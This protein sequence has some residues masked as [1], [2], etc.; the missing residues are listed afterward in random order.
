[1][2]YLTNENNKTTKEKEEW[3][4]EYK[5]LLEKIKIIRKNIKL[6]KKISF[7]N[8][9]YNLVMQELDKVNNQYMKIECNYNRLLEKYQ[10]QHNILKNMCNYYE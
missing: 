8:N 5:Q 4:E 6:S 10:V 9:L 7:K 1:M 2:A 3:L